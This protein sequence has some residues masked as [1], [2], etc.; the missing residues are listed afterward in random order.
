[1]VAA[2]AVI[3]EAAAAEIVGA[4]VSFA[5]VTLTPAEVVVLP[6][7]SRATADNVWAPLAAVVVFQEREYGAAVSSVPRLAPFS[8]NWTPAIPTLSLALADTVTVFET[9]APAAG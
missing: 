9:V 5:T 8:L 2:T 3:D 1:M 7:A 6:A 4:V